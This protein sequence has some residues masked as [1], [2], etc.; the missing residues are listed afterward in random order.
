[1]AMAADLVLEIKATG[2]YL[3][4]LPRG[5][6]KDAAE[7]RIRFLKARIDVV[8]L[9]TAHA[10]ELVGAVQST[11]WSRKAPKDKMRKSEMQQHIQDRM[12]ICASTPLATIN[13]VAR[14]NGNLQDYENIINYIPKDWWLEEHDFD[15][16]LLQLCKILGLRTASEDTLAL[17]TGLSLCKVLGLAAAI[18]EDA[19]TLY[20]SLQV[21]KKKQKNYNPRKGDDD[22]AATHLRILPKPVEL[23]ERFPSLYRQAMEMG[24]PDPIPFD[25]R[26]FKMFVSTIPMRKSNMA[27]RNV[28]TVHDTSRSLKTLPSHDC[29]P[30]EIPL[31]MVPMLVR[32]ELEN[33]IGSTQMQHHEDEESLLKNLLVHTPLGKKPKPLVLMDSP[34]ASDLSAKTPCSKVLKRKSL[35]EI[36]TELLTGLKKSKEKAKDHDDSSA[37]G[38][39]ESSGGDRKEKASI[40]KKGKSKGQMTKKGKSTSSRKG[41]SDVDKQKKKKSLTYRICNERTRDC[42]RIRCSDRSSFSFQYAKYG[43][44][45]KTMKHAKAWIKKNNP[46]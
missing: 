27:L 31:Q 37:E 8:Q 35:A 42:T 22:D 7:E 38:E 44:E 5:A 29:L 36:T 28:L 19:R 20:D 24:E 12:M 34:P 4:E 23:K 15:H 3:Q 30:Q 17:L 21:M 26:R 43:G 18:R 40:R 11:E 2:R 46:K 13:S 10:A 9:T 33:L 6:V 25:E 14:P 32:K 39:E 1:M 45:A 41:K 16:R